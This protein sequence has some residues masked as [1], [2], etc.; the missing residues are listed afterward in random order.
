MLEED[1]RYAFRYYSEEEGWINEEEADD[2]EPNEFGAT[3]C[4]V[5]T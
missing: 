1:N 4:V 3:N 5:E 2:F